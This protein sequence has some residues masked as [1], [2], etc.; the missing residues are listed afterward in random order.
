MNVIQITIVV[1]AIKYSKRRYTIAHL[2]RAHKMKFTPLT[3]RPNLKTTPNPDDPR[4][5]CDSCNWTFKPTSQYR[6]HLKRVH[7]IIRASSRPTPNPNISP[8][9]NDLNF[10]CK[11]CQ[12]GFKC[13]STYRMHLR[14][15][16]KI[17]LES[18]L[19][20]PIYDPTI[21]N[22]DTK[23][24]TNTSCVICKIKYSRKSYYR[25]HMEKVHKDGKNTP[26]RRI[27]STNN[28]N[29]RPDL[30]DPNVT[31]QCAKD[32]TQLAKV[33]IVISI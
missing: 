10:Y 25:K 15:V 33:I 18:L 5:H 11:S 4:N 3:S 1:C 29:I 16:H 20:Q 31:V 26:V 23:D 6:L 22:E 32:V 13:R 17:E 24:P 27:R 8:D 21:S 7:N 2:R 9:I 19:K 12:Y 30:N 14:G 28:V